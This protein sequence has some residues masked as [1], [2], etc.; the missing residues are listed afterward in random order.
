MAK[1]INNIKD[2]DGLFDILEDDADKIVFKNPVLNGKDKFI[3]IKLEVWCFQN[4]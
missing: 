1:S 2:I 4:K 3:I